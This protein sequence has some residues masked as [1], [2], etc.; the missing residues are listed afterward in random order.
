MP[1]PGTDALPLPA[2]AGPPPRLRAEIAALGGLPG[3]LVL[4][5]GPAA[6]P[7]GVLL[8]V[9]RPT[10]ALLR[11]AGFWVK[12]ETPDAPA[13]ARRLAARLEAAAR[14]AGVL[15][16]RAAPGSAE[17]GLDPALL[18]LLGL[19]GGTSPYSE[20]W[21]GNALP[22]P[23]HA[24]PLYAQTTR[25]TCGPATLLMALGALAGRMPSRTDEI[26]LWREATSIVSLAG[27]G[28]C[29]PFGL[30]VAAWARGLLPEIRITTRWPTLTERI[31]TEEK[32]DLIGFAQAE[33]QERAAAAGIPVR[34]GDFAL[35]ELAAP[36]AAGGL[37]LLLVDQFPTHGRH[38]PHWLLL[39]HAWEGG[40]LANDPW[41]DPLR[42][43]GLA[44]AENLPL[45]L[46][47]LER[48]ARFGEPPYRAAIILPP[49]G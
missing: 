40:F 16:L 14:Q 31:D 15:A 8:A 1:E 10:A 19:D 20:R 22:L 47:D 38:S 11:L 21:L 28:G 34:H 35:A 29:D 32:R 6:D 33:F 46:E 39:H 37:V 12:P 3:N 42:R 26:A 30:A 13:V 43:E 7:A 2:T 45:R 49:P 4:T 23:R 25:F 24:I 17:E 27:P 9:G 36:I 44:D 41:P 48:M 18:P 5:E